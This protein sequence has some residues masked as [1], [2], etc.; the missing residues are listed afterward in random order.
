M[1]SSMGFAPFEPL[2]PEAYA[3]Q[4]PE[5]GKVPRLAGPTR[6]D[7]HQLWLC[8]EQRQD[9]RQAEDRARRGVE[10][11]VNARDEG[12]VFRIVDGEAVRLRQVAPPAPAHVSDAKARRLAPDER[13]RMLTL[14]RPFGLRCGK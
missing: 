5:L 3:S 8:L 2:R 6:V 10:L 13:R 12:V 7:A 11:V 9:V 4:V 14:E 1:G